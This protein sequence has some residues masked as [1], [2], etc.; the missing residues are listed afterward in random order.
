MCLN[1][2]ICSQQLRCWSV[3]TYFHT[4]VLLSQSSVWSSK[5]H[6]EVC[7]VLIVCA[8]EVGIL[9]QLKFKS[10][11]LSFAFCTFLHFNG[12][13]IFPDLNPTSL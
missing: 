10:Q 3:P 11:W 8:F 2:V 1:H 7:V 4:V 6:L 9:K 13:V 12:I 5:F